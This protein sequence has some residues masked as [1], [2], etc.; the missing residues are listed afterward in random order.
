MLPLA[1]VIR[2]SQEENLN[3]LAESDI[4]LIQTTAYDYMEIFAKGKHNQNARVLPWPTF[5]F[6]AFHPD[7]VISDR[8]LSPL[9]VYHSAIAIKAYLM[10]MTVSETVSLYRGEVFDRLGYLEHASPSLSASRADLDACGLDAQELLKSWIASGV[11]AH[12]TNHPT[13]FVIRT[14]ATALL[15]K[16]G[17]KIDL[18][19]PEL[20]LNDLLASGKWPVHR[21]IAERLEV[22]TAEYF[23]VEGQQCSITEFIE[24]SFSCYQETNLTEALA[25]ERLIS[26]REAYDALKTLVTQSRVH[27]YANLP[28]SAFWRKSV[29]QCSAEDF[30]PV[31]KPKFTFGAGNKIATAGSCFAQN[32]ARV[33]IDGGMPFLSVEP[34]PPELSEEEALR[35][36]YKL[37]SARYGNIYT[38]RHLLQL[39]WRS[40]GAYVPVDAVWRR[41]DGRFVDPYR[42]QLEP[43][44]YPTPD[45]VIVST[46]EHL[47]AVRHLFA[48]ADIF[49]FTVGL[50]ETWANKTD[51]AV[52][53]VA[54]GVVAGEFK[55]D[56]Y[57][58][59][60]MSVAAVVK[61]LTAS[62]LEMKRFNPSIRVLLTV[63]PVPLV[64]TYSGEH[65]IRA[66]TYSKSVLRAAV[67]EVCA[68]FEDVDY[69]PSYEIIC[70]AGSDGRYFHS[71]RRSVSHEGVEHVMRILRRHYFNAS[72]FSY[73]PVAHMTPIAPTSR[74]FSWLRDS[75]LDERENRLFDSDWYLRTNPDVASEGWDPVRHYRLHGMREC[76][77][78]NPV[79]DPVYYLMQCANDPRARR[80]PLRHYLTIGHLNGLR[81]NFLFDLETFSESKLGN[82]ARLTPLEQY[83]EFNQEA[84]LIFSDGKKLE[85]WQGAPENKQTDS[86]ISDEIRESVKLLCDENALDSRCQ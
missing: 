67:E 44:G 23:V 62:I 38:A 75:E 18:H 4:T 46:K 84:S 15:G 32:I 36:G 71:D 12:T 27:P 22:P 69:F 60:N 19:H 1:E 77:R 81:P 86:I 65:V 55:A 10:G 7:L 29:G 13:L 83:L 57:E 80:N 68:S 49:I 28:S 85:R 56:R 26:N 70:G 43:E 48:T 5:Y 47:K 30:D 73:R 17:L 54:P 64:A 16:L 61:D 79:F 40:T 74:R 35:R 82:S 52:Y 50:T 31:V 37:F 34:P 20:F 41:P 66:T 78:P 39:L 2:V 11:F 76:R 24:R 33:L 58:F 42:P 25:P 9:G 63:S 53:P 45:E 21:E 8:F 3:R 14:I 72:E 6:S 51:G 59:V